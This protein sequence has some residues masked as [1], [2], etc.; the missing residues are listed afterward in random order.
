VPVEFEHEALVVYHQDAELRLELRELRLLRRELRVFR[1][2]L[3]R[4]LRVE[5][6][7]VVW[8]CQEVGREPAREAA[9]VQAEEQ[10]EEEA[11]DVDAD[12][13]RLD[14]LD[15][16]HGD[17]RLHA[18]HDPPG[19]V[20]L[21]GGGGEAVHDTV[22]NLARQGLHDHEMPHAPSSYIRTRWK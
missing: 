11:E 22:G 3:Q 14:A 4:V 8:A 12:A 9:R 1:R 10:S 15:V 7:I 18:C 19:D 21:Q 20:V 2:E 17:L 6:V 13:P 5:L 16:L